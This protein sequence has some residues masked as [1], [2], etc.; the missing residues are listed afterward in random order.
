MHKK[1]AIAEIWTHVPG[2]IAV[3]IKRNVSEIA[4][5]VKFLEIYGHKVWIFDLIFQNI[6]MSIDGATEQKRIS[7]LYQQERIRLKMIVKI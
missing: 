2:M 7:N 4:A 3:M 1:F 6:K 5:V